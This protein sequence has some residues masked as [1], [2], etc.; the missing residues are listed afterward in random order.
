MPPGDHYHCF[1]CSA[2]GDAIDFVRGVDRSSTFAQ[3]RAI[4]CGDAFP[5]RAPSPPR[6]SPRPA[7]PRPAGWQDFAR[8][9][10]EEAEAALWSGRGSE[11]R[12]YLHD[13]GLSDETIR[14]ARLGLR[15][16]DAHIEGI[17]PDKPA[18][19]P[20]G[21]T[22]PWFEGTDLAMVNIRR[23]EGSD[24]KY[25]AIRGSRRGGIYPSKAVI[26]TGRPLIIAEGEFDALLLNQEL[27]GLASV[28][29]L[30]S[31]GARP[32]PSVL[33]AMLGASPW[34]VAVDPDGAGQESAS[35]W[36]GRSMRCRRVPPPNGFKDWTEAHQGGVC[37]RR[38]WGD[39]LAGVAIPPLHTWDELA[40]VR[41]GPGVVD[42][43]FGLIVV[44]PDLGRMLAALSDPGAGADAYAIAE[45]EAMRDEDGALGKGR[46]V[47]WTATQR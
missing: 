20:A 42:S 6:L 19:V 23:P 35:G 29:T 24:P 11:A 7:P 17:F 38:W 4:V 10:V 41:W 32:S 9:I 8:G 39:Y 27:A 45:R 44:H 12:D 13:R 31:A 21:I 47:A 34:L 26:A 1:G 28:I 2:H 14:A 46:N 15:P 25:W 18:W 5:R 40:E 3:A 16:E 37:L 30:G 36:L 43:T 33:G 22:I